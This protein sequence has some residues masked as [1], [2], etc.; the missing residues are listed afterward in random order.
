MTKDSQERM[1]LKELKN[2]LEMFEQT[3]GYSSYEEGHKELAYELVKSAQKLV[4]IFREDQ[5]VITEESG[6]C[7]DVPSEG[8]PMTTDEYK[9]K[10]KA[11]MIEEVLKHY[12][13]FK[14]HC[15]ASEVCIYGQHLRE[16]KPESFKAY[17][18]NFYIQRMDDKAAER[19]EIIKKMN[20][21]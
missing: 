11:E 12:Y 9:E 19:E 13:P 18:M 16:L 15:I 10:R 21:L 8:R 14:D 4:D 17:M 7:E 6:G 20:N 1:Y 5:A 2:K 3:G